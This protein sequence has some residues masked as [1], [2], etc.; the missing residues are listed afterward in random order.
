MRSSYRLVIKRKAEKEIRGLPRAIRQ[1]VVARIQSLAHEP[2]PLGC[3]KLTSQQAYRIR[4]G[5]YRVIYTIQDDCLVVE[6][7]RVA[8]RSDAYRR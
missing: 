7:V 8:H 5:N 6:V 1:Q 3:E 4:S 2:R